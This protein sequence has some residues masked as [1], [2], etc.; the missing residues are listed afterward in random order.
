MF[1]VVGFMHQGHNLET[2]NSE[3][4]VLKA[5]NDSMEVKRV[6]ME[7][8]I[9]ERVRCVFCCVVFRVALCVAGLLLLCL[10][11]NQ[12]CLRFAMGFAVLRSLLLLFAIA[13]QFSGKRNV[14]FGHPLFVQARQ[15]R[16]LATI[17]ADADEELRSVQRIFVCVA[18]TSKLACCR[19]RVQEKQYSQI[20]NEQ[21][22]LNQQLIER[23]QV[24]VC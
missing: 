21:R 16:K 23:N 18:N 13:S 17:I 19:C 24:C 22:V 2:I 10:L 1:V 14:R 9:K 15:I 20:V 8:V 11:R 7:D 12:M 4:T 3:V 6:E 5:Q